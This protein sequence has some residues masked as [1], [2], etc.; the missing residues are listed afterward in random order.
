MPAFR[1]A[2]ESATSTDIPLDDQRSL[3]GLVHNAIT[4]PLRCAD[5]LIGWCGR[6]FPSELVLACANFENKPLHE[7]AELGQRVASA[8]GLI[9]REVW[10]DILQLDTTERAQLEDYARKD[11]AFGGE[12]FERNP[13][14]TQC[15]LF[16]EWRQATCGSNQ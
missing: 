7:Q 13:R 5:K 8:M 15:L 1:A 2:L 14:Y 16:E 11:I 12:S 3:A 9:E 4:E 6:P 10:A